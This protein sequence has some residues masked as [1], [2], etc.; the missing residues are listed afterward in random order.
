MRLYNVQD[1]DRADLGR[2]NGE[3]PIIESGQIFS[4]IETLVEILTI[5]SS[6]LNCIS[7]G[8]VMSQKV[9]R[10]M[11]QAVGLISRRT[12]WS[13]LRFRQIITATL[14]GGYLSV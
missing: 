4:G 3:V 2:L 14:V 7:R 9:S 6:R 5:N 11:M 1:D 8:I 13:E 10:S 12:S